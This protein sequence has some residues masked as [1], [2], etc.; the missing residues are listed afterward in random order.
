MKVVSSRLHSGL[1]C[2]PWMTHLPRRPGITGQ[3]SSNCSLLR[4]PASAGAGVGGVKGA[5]HLYL[6]RYFPDSPHF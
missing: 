4:D 2:G 5:D 1:R 6:I 3:I